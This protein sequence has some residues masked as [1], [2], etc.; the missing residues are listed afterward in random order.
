MRVFLIRFAL[1]LFKLV[2]IVCEVAV[3]STSD[4]NAFNR[5]MFYVCTYELLLHNLLWTVIFT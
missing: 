1:G 2:L 4:Y 5:W 3:H